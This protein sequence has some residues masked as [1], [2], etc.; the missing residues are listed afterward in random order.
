MSYEHDIFISYRRSDTIGPWVKNHLA[1][2]LES[3]LNQVAPYNVSVFCDFKM[4]D[5]VN[6]P[7]ELKRRIHRSR[8]LLSIWSADYFRSTWCMAEWQSFRE[9]ETRL[10]LFSEE[11]PQ[12]LVYPV[13]HSDGKYYHVDAKQT[14]CQKDFSE[15]SY[16]DD[17]FK[18]SVKYLEFDNLVRQMADDLALRLGSV[19]DWNNNFPILE[20]L[21]LEPVVMGRTVI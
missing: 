7:E 13:R 20:P 3:R 4:D 12:G 18:L 14:Q 2:R 9:R 21:P 1:P 16:P 19:P 6:W 8:L 10:G 15:L 17:V 5:G 11:H